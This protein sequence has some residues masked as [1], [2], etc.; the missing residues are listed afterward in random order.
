V[1]VGSDLFPVTQSDEDQAIITDLRNQLMFRFNSQQNL[2][3]IFQLLT[4][5]TVS[6]EWIFPDSQIL[7]NTEK[8]RD[9]NQE[10]LF[11]LGFPQVLITGEAQRTGSSDP[12]IAM[13]SP[14]KTM[15]NFRRKIIRIISEVCKQVAELNGFKTA[16]QVS[17]TSLNLHAFA[18]FMS[19]LGKAYEIS[20]ISRTS[21]DEAIGY[22]FTD[23][24]SKLVEENTALQDSGLP[25][26]GPT[27]NSRNPN[28]PPQANQNNQNIQNNNQSNN[29]TAL[30][31]GANNT[32]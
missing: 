28:N 13:I 16:P 1:K 5:H 30:N 10:I 17:F 11:G 22:D 21:F 32:Q 19:A 9:I 12:E 2:E 20:G 18:D 15:E 27:P 26:F 23:E 7:L 29:N 4:N 3:R 25:E 24:L 8:Y 31:K 6:L 14:V